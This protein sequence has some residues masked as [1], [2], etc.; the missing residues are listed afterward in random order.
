MPDDQDEHE[1]KEENEFI[2]NDSI[3]KHQ[4]DYNSSSCFGDNVPEISAKN[5]KVDDD[6]PL[7][8]APGEGKIPTDFPENWEALSFPTHFP[9]GR[10]D[11]DEERPVKLR[12]PFYFT[13]RAMNHDPR[14]AND[15]AF[16]FAANAY[17]EKKQINNNI[18]LAFQR[19]NK[20]LSSSGQLTYTLNDPHMVLDGI[21]NTPKYWQKARYE[22]NAKVENFGPFD[23]FF[24]LS[25]ADMR[26]P[27]NFTS[28]LDGHNVVYENKHGEEEIT[29]DGQS[30]DDFLKAYPSKHSLIRTNLLNSTLNFNHRLK[31]FIKHIVMSKHALLLIDHYNYRIEFQFRGAPHAHG[32]LWVDWDKVTQIPQQHVENF[33]Q[34]KTLIRS[35]SK[36]SDQHKDSMARIADHAISVSL[37]DT[38]VSEI[39][40]EVQVHHHTNKACRKYGTTCRFNFPKF[41]TRKTLIS[42]PSNYAFNSEEEKDLTMTR[43]KTILDAVREILEDDDQMKKVCLHKQKELQILIDADKDKWRISQIIQNAEY[44]NNK[45]CSV[46]KNLHHHFCGKI[47][48]NG[49][50]DVTQS[51]VVHDALA[52]NKIKIDELLKERIEFMLQQANFSI[53]KFPDVRSKLEEYENA[54]SVNNRGYMPFYKRDVAEIMVN[55]YN[56]EWISSWN[57]NM[58][59]QLCLDFYAIITY[60][61]DYYSKDDSGTMDMLINALKDAENEDLRTKLKTVASV[62]LTHRQMGES[63]AYYRLFPHMHL[64]DSNIEAVF[65]PTGFNPSHF[66]K[67]IDDDAQVDGENLIEVEGREGKYQEKASMYEKYLR[68]DCSLHHEIKDLCYAQFVKRYKSVRTV[69]KSFNYKNWNHQRCMT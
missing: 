45:Q 58:D 55:S 10:N 9:D 60:I 68:R 50:A 59:I 21:K 64:K 49:M 29:V 33:K 11:K 46:P 42:S 61:S 35:N 1:N 2:K 37:R 23:L 36:L 14:F 26:W 24:T 53:E 34:A 19:G 30:L 63:E 7:V 43:Y 48:E 4:F 44:N 15:P 5:N 13:Q 51:K 66:L 12:D 52:I 22:L 6:K 25:C 67:K 38:S 65:A 8:L 18:S 57:G 41:P 47:Q 17:I 32:V 28:I 40:K 27:E 69:P 31:M 54:L 62:F 56:P 39:V 16:I 3:R 20:R